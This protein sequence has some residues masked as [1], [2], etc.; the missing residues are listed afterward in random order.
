MRAC[1]SA[2]YYRP[3]T[4]GLL[5]IF[6]LTAISANDAHADCMSDCQ[7]AYTSCTRGFNER[8][9]ATQRSI[10][11]NRCVTG[12]QSLYGAIA[13]SDSTGA[14]GFSFQYRTRSGAELRAV[15]ECTKRGA[16]DCEAKVW[17]RGCGSLAVGPDNVYGSAFADS[18]SEARDLAIGYCQEQSGGRSCVSKVA[19]CAIAE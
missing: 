16:R 15:D 10:C 5:T 17:F 11:Q 12:A 14:Y 8:D 2:I 6:L 13:F 7:G 4:L 19:V 1:N 18:K 9:C 3:P